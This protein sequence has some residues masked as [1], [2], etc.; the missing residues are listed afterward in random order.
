[1]LVGQKQLASYAF[2]FFMLPKPHPSLIFSASFFVPLAP[3]PARGLAVPQ[4]SLPVAF[5][6]LR[7]VLRP[8][9]LALL[10]FA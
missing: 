3:S 5:P 6:S 10:Y 4:R 8:G 7:T 2:I 1:M 9:M